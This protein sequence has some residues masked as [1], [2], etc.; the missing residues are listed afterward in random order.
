MVDRLVV[1]IDLA[2]VPAQGF[3]P[4]KAVLESISVFYAKYQVFLM[5]CSGFSSDD[6]ISRTL[7]SLRIGSKY[8]AHA[9]PLW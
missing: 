2:K 4:L 3:A 6:Y 1:A 7:L 8:C 9:S 5:F